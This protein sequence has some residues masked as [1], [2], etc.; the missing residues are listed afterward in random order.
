[1][2]KYQVFGCNM[3]FVA[4]TVETNDK[5]ELIFECNMKEGKFKYKMRNWDM[6]VE[7]LSNIMTVENK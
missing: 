5:N 6:V 1:M 3:V 2:A 4:N 7:Q